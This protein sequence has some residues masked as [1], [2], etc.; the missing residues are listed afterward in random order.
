LGRGGEWVEAE[1]RGS[2]WV[3]EGRCRVTGPL[4][5]EEEQEDRHVVWAAVLPMAEVLQEMVLCK[6]ISELNNGSSLRR[7]GGRESYA[8]GLLL[9][10]SITMLLHLWDFFAV[11]VLGDW[12]SV[13]GWCCS[14]SHALVV[15]GDSGGIRSILASPSRPYGADNLNRSHKLT[16]WGSG[17]CHEVMRLKSPERWVAEL[18]LELD[19]CAH[20]PQWEN[21]AV[22]SLLW[23]P[24]SQT[25][26]HRPCHQLLN[27]GLKGQDLYVFTWIYFVK[28][29]WFMY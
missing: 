13:S 3:L 2:H 20:L 26:H 9:S 5:R 25:M 7:R 22:K 28:I 21:F 18:G 27:S 24:P 11:V 29:Q 15:N 17:E 16:A 8:P 10:S 23:L 19:S 4:M 12:E 6:I 1:V 14:P